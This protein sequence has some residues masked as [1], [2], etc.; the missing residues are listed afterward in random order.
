MENQRKNSI[1]QEHYVNRS[2]EPLEKNYEILKKV[3]EGGF[4]C[5]YKARHRLTKIYRSIKI[6]EK[7]KYSKNR[8]K[9]LKNEIEI[10]KKL[11]HPHIIK[12]FE[13]YENSEKIFIISEFLTGGDL[14]QKIKNIKVFSE[15]IASFYIKQILSALSY[16]HKKNIAHLDLKPENIMFC[17]KKKNVSVLKI[18]DFGISQNS[19]PEKKKKLNFFKKL[20]SKKKTKKPEN[21]KI[22][23]ITQNLQKSKNSEKKEKNKILGS[24]YYIS[25]ESLHGEY[26]TKNDIWSLGVIMYIMLCGYP[27]FNEKSI[28]KIIKKIKIGVFEFNK[29]DFGNISSEGKMM[30]RKMLSYDANK[31]PCAE[32][33]LK[34]IWFEKCKKKNFIFF[35]LKSKNNILKKM[36]NFKKSSIL[37]NGITLYY[38]NFFDL[39]KEKKKIL[40]IFKEIDKNGNCELNKNELIECYLKIYNKKKAEKI[41]DEILNE[42]DFNNSNSIDFSEFLTFYFHKKKKLLKKNLNYIF[43]MID[44]DNSGDICKNELKDFFGI[45]EDEDLNKMICEVDTDGNGKISFKEFKDMFKN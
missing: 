44:K 20:F 17:N 40:K 3:G 24:P 28:S 5:V 27:P 36:S 21:P 4:S 14:F 34:N 41:V 8:Q 7:S 35:D 15:K 19:N 43:Q 11:D 18:I 16:L 13:Y 32:K 37:Q 33:L 22:E 39:K 42:F 9:N 38:V 31:R 23:D 30:I 29:N 10:L 25:P 26:S 12:I 6:I 45:N 2:Y 1:N